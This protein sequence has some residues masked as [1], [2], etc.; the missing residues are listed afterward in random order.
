M[1]GT[2]PD[3]W[4]EGDGEKAQRRL[5]RFREMHVQPSVPAIRQHNH[6]KWDQLVLVDQTHLKY[7]K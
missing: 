6:E 2:V 5:G 4:M 7:N 3:E 1:I